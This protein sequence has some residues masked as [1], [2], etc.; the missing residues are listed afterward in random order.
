MLTASGAAWPDDAAA[1]DLRW[2]MATETP[3]KGRRPLAKRWNWTAWRVRNL[4]AKH[5]LGESPTRARESAQLPP[6]RRPVAAQPPPSARPIPQ[7]ETLTNRE[8]PPSARPAAAQ[9][10]PSARP[11]AAQLSTIEENK[12]KNKNKGA[13]SLPPELL[14]AWKRAAVACGTEAPRSPR[15]TSETGKRLAA[16]VAEHGAPAIIALL[17]WLANS[18]ANNAAFIR[19]EHTPLTVIRPRNIDRYLALATKTPPPRPGEWRSNAK[20]PE[21]TDAQLDEIGALTDAF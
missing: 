16:V 18:P 2:H 10:P 1:F 17:D 11:V 15:A 13:L 9:L 5:D 12:N 14:D 6:S 7:G 3:I 19:A 20:P 8:E 4:L 21:T